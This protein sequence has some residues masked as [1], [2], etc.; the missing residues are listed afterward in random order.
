MKPRSLCLTLVLGLAAGLW[1]CQDTGV[2]A[3][4]DVA[5][6]FGVDCDKK[7]DHP[8]CPID[9]PP[10]P[11]PD[12]DPTAEVWWAGGMVG[13]GSEENI[14]T[15][16]DRRLV[17][18]APPGVS[19][20][21]TNTQGLF[22]ENGVYVQD[23]LISGDLPAQCQVD[24][25]ESNS[26]KIIELAGMLVDEEQPAYTG[27]KMDADLSRSVSRKS[28][29]GFNVWSSDI[30]PDYEF[31]I[32]RRVKLSKIAPEYGSPKVEEFLEF[33]GGGD[34]PEGTTLL[35]FSEGAVVIWQK[36]ASPDVPSYT[37]VCQNMDEV[38]VTVTRN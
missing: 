3:P 20:N 25:P 30:D 1:A 29:V 36:A 10:D 11:D 4:D 17:V 24:F 16:T 34:V 32:I 21:F 19:S 33:P 7:P 35:N 31:H 27:S 22:M 26:D 18:S 6:S 38:W 9:P 23:G 8:Q 12:P 28:Q 2:V 5:P 37:L 14:L 15:D 13:Y